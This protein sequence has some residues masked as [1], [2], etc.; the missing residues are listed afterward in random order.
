M[1]TA[2]AQAWVPESCTLAGGQREARLSEFSELLAAAVLTASRPAP[3]LLQLTLRPG[4]EQAARAAGLAAAETG[5][6]SF[7]TFTLTVAAGSLELAVA[8]PPGRE[9]V[10]DGLAALAAGSPG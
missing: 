3:G 7:F 2:S 1:D 10:L 4:P 8:V 9:G 6:C 5:C